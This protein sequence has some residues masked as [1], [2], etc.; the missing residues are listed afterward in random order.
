MN[1]AVPSPSPA[2]LI[3]IDDPALASAEA[4]ERV[5]AIASDFAGNLAAPGLDPSSPEYRGLWESEAWI[6]EQR[7]RAA[8]GSRAWLRH[9]QAL[10]AAETPIRDSN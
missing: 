4:Q 1:A 7:F 2:A 3:D 8:F 10:S 5:A 9:R 6:A